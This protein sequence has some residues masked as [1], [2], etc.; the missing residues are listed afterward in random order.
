MSKPV[1]LGNNG[2][3]DM[4][5]PSTKNLFAMYDKIPAQQCASFRDPTEGLWSDTQL[6]EMFFS[7]QNIQ[8]LQNGIRA[9]VYERSNGQYVIGPQDC[10]SLKIIMRSV[11]LQH[12]ANQNRNIAGQVVELNK[13]VLDYCIYQVYGE[14]QG[15]MKY[16][17]DV[18]SLAVPIAHPVMEQGQ[19]KE[20]ILKPWF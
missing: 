3:V 16:L 15:Y 9:G 12:A 4:N 14:A 7:K 19:S 5:G 17:R 6:S 1:K 18:S 8:I 11:F 10:D 13:I 2:R 20:L